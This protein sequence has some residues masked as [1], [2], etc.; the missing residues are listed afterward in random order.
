MTPTGLEKHLRRALG[1]PVRVVARPGDVRVFVEQK[2]GRTLIGRGATTALALQC[3]VGAAREV[4]EE[5]RVERLKSEKTGRFF[6]AVLALVHALWR[7]TLAARRRL[8]G[9]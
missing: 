5:E 8:L 6:L 4:V 1:L 3:V 2:T 9:A 7:W